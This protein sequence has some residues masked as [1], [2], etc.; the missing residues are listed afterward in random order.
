[1]NLWIFCVPINVTAFGC[2][3]DVN[4]IGVE[5]IGE[6]GGDVRIVEDRAVLSC[7]RDSK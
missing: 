4:S 7:A 3:V 6:V 2:D 1:V 5:G